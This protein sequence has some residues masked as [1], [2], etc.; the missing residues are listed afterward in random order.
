MAAFG[1]DTRAYVPSLDGMRAVCVLLVCVSHFGLGRVVPGGFG[2][3]VFFF[4]SGALITGQLTAERARTRRIDFRGFYARRVLRLAPAALVYVVVT[5]LLFVR[6]G[7]RISASG[8]FWAVMH[9]ANYYDLFVGYD[10]AGT[11]VRHPF[12]ILWSLAVEEHFY[13]LIPPLLALLWRRQ[14]VW[15]LCGI[16]VVE[17][18]WR[19]VLFHA[20][21]HAG[22]LSLPAHLPLCGWRVDDRL[23]KATDTRLDSLAWGALLALLPTVRP[24]Q[25]PFAR[26]AALAA[27]AV[28]FSV[29]SPWFREVL[30]YSLQG[31]ALFVLIPAIT[32]ED[33]LVRRLLETRPA[34]LVGRMSYSIYLWH[35]GALMIA[36][37]LLAADSVGW[38]LL[39]AGLTALLSAM[40]FFLVERPMLGLRHRFG[41]H[42]PA[43]LAPAV[44]APA[45]AP[46][47]VTV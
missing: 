47:G 20:C 36:D 27:L 9:G 21:S 23:Y 35:W 31:A 18:V 29:P 28:G 26:I 1:Q 46:R 38:A 15:V 17:I 3:T 37:R 12:G 39:A 4:I 7:G 41:S 5:G 11:D 16:V 14:A 2:V 43:R 22:G 45:D 13:L 44:I 32:R 33:S 8:W 24:T 25:T 30:R 42:A 6:F 19:A 40:S 10:N 34:V